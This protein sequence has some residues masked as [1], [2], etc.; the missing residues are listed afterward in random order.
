MRLIVVFGFA[1]SI[2]LPG[3]HKE[4]AP[5]PVADT[6]IFDVVLSDL[7]GNEDLG[8]ASRRGKTSQIVVSDKTSPGGTLANLLSNNSANPAWKVPLEVRADLKGRNRKGTSW[9]LALYQPA[10]PNI[11]VR[12][13]ARIQRGNEFWDG[14]P[15]ARCY[16]YPGLPGYSSD[17]Q[18]ALLPFM[19]GPAPHGLLRC[20]YLLTK[21]DRRWEIVWRFIEGS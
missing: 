7:I 6:A 3:C 5:V 2:V 1:I 8:D 4:L 13:L 21:V 19:V 14:F 20:Y 16:V 18:R 10:T 9:S 11:L 17:G 15:Y 12:D